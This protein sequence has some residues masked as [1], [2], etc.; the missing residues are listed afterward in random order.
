MHVS[1]AVGTAIRKSTEAIMDGN[2][3]DIRTKHFNE[4]IKLK[5]TKGQ[6]T[7]YSY[8]KQDSPNREL[9]LLQR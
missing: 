5:T 1:W 2:H 6:G 8:L 9:P 7:K 3:H 4:I